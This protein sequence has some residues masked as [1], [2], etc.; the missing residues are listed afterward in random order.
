MAERTIL[1]IISPI[2]AGPSSSHTAGAVRIGLLTRNIYNDDFDEVKIILYNS[3]AQTGLGHGTDKGIISGLLGF[4]VDN[5]IIKDVFNSYE[6][7]KINYRFE[8]RE[9]FAH[10]PN[11]V[12]FIF[13]G[14]E[15]MEISAQSI[16]GGEVQ[17]TK[18]N[19]FDVDI[20][21]K[22]NTIVIVME[23]RKGT[24]SQIANIIQKN[25][26]NIATFNC[27][28]N[29]K[30][31]SAYCSIE[32]DGEINEKIIQDIKNSVNP[33]LIRYIKKLPQ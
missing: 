14:K 11:A 2:M 33:E 32:L 12:D 8:F 28:R 7:S 13:K 9:S 18:I 26:I 22:L 6:A 21:G 4:G 17:V 20:R 23:D 24:I 29:S 31:S 1:D 19:G 3:Y 15:D 25:D 5:T 30:G 10:H 27:N 16:G